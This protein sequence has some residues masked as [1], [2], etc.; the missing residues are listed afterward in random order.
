MKNRKFIGIIFA[1]AISVIVASC[2]KDDP[3]A[4]QVPRPPGPPTTA[5]VSAVELNGGSLNGRWTMTLEQVVTMRNDTLWD[6]DTLRYP[7]G[8]LMVQ[9]VTGNQL[10]IIDATGPDTT[11]YTYSVSGNQLIIE[12]G[13]D[14]IIFLYGISPQGVMRWSN[15][16]TWTSGPN[17]YRDYNDYL[18]ERY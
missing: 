16:D 5:E 9:F 3:N 12:D 4:I 14:D 13:V 10:W 7:A 6:F 17:V 11:L 8:E 15:T 18:F 2:K 1:I